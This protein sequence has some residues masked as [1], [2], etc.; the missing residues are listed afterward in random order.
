MRPLHLA[1]EGLRSFRSPVSIDF[2]G[3]DHVAIVGDTGAG[4]S[5]ILEA[6]TYALYGQT[7]FT[8]QANQEL[9]NDTSLHLRVVL[10]FRVSGE[11]WEVARTLRRD[12]Q[13]RVGS[14]N[15]QLRRLGAD[16]EAVEQ[17]EQVKPVN[18]GIKALIGLDSD[19]FLRTVV[20]PQGRFARLLVE[21]RPTD[22]GRILRQVWRTD[23][24]E[25]AGALAG[26]ARQEAEKLRERLAQ[27]A[28]GYPDD[29]AAHLAALQAARETAGRNAG[30]ATEDERAAA[31]AH[32]ALLSAATARREAAG[33]TERLRALDVDG[34]AGVLAPIAAAERRIAGEETAHEQRQAGLEDELAR[35]PA[36][37]G[38][39]REEVAAAVTTLSSLGDLAKAAEEAAADLR[40]AA[41]DVS[42]KQTEARRRAESAEAARQGAA[43]HATKRAPLDEAAAA[44]R[45]RRD[46][47][48]QKLARCVERTAERDA[49]RQRLDAL[50][51]EEAERAESLEAA[52]QAARR[53][54]REAAGADDHLAAARRSE[55]AAL[56]ARDLHAGDACPICR[57][58]LPDDWEAPHVA[59]LADA[60]K[61]ARAAHQAAR[62]ADAAVTALR[63]ERNALARQ[64]AEAETGLADLQAALDTARRELA[65]EAGL[66]GLP[67]GT[68][69]TGASSPAA[70]TAAQPGAPDAARPEPAA[71]M[72]ARPGVPDAEAPLPER[73]PLLAPLEVACAETAAMLAGHDRLAEE[74]RADAAAEDTAAGVAREAAANAGAAAD[75]SRRL[76]VRAVER[77][78]AAVRV[79]PEP[80]RPSLGLPADA[81]ELHEVDLGPVGEQTESAR[82]RARVLG[83]RETEQRRLRSAI[84]DTRKARSA[85]ARR[86]AEEVDTPLDELVR[87]L[88]T[89]RDV[90]VES[91]R[92]LA[93]DVDVPDA[94]STRE[95]GALESNVAALRTKAAELSR[96]AAEHARAAVERADAARAELAAIRTRVDPATDLDTASATRVDPATDL[97]PD[98]ATRVDPAT[99]LGPDAV[100]DAARAKA[101]DARFRAR[102]ASEAA[103]DFAA[104]ADDVGGLRGLL[105]EVDER[106]L[107]LGDL[108]DALKPGAFLKWL[109]LRRSRR[110]LVH[111][112]RMLGEMSG[113]KYAFVD[114][115]ETDEQWQVLDADSGRPRSPAS[116]SGGEQFIAS[117][118][119]ALGMVEMMARSGGRLE[120]LFLDE[121][122]GS[123]DRNNLDAAVQALG[124]VAAGGRMVGVISHVRAVAEQI[125]HVLAVTRGATGS[126]AEWLTSGQRERLS[127]SDTGLEAASAL[128]GLLE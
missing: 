45:R 98:A 44:A 37:D 75:Q 40:A 18:D 53:A 50:R 79:V 48:E 67:L 92:R 77:L 41:S 26:G 42:R 100:L 95:V 122:F 22:R 124:T 10:R 36:D 74:L 111:A 81:A 46:A 52:Q 83:A 103:D 24:L 33:V 20:L 127:E 47:V 78:E 59:G 113:G 25:A 43:D 62:E 51:A 5:S 116:L 115:G 93:L 3:R 80:F 29:P 70:P 31:A 23:E 120:S 13:G 104:I 108:E 76:T 35:V 71:P 54:T 101:E 32:E 4:K 82:A 66:T 96:A 112:S 125:E 121:G 69:L 65:Q 57:R 72:A 28:S 19:A 85:L 8:A 56:A 61:I 106:A 27:A 99:D 12:G 94:V 90:L 64:A 117:L 89:C 102:R 2:A 126:R 110:L 123:L 105:H 109:T 86:R 60:E 118:S 107:A 87:E 38:P 9:M 84:E 119:L 11:T 49:A 55:S 128:A 30:A 16:G 6:V 1:I 58:D 34:V 15:A 14:P 114:P 97:G 88:H 68:G 7:T 73:D 63:T 21:D 17:V 91:V 39:T